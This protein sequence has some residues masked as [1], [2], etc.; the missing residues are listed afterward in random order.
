MARRKN[1]GVQL[2]GVT[3]DAN[4][5]AFDWQG[6]SGVHQAV[7]SAFGGGTAKLQQLL[8]DNTTWVDVPGSSM[9]AQGQVNFTAPA[10][11]MRSVL[12]GSTTPSA[13]TTYVIGIPVNG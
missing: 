12:A 13:L 4:G 8:Q 10:G 6:G 11:Q 1:Y 3:A 7:S 9:T 5:A 2:N